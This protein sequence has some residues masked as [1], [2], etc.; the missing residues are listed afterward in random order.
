[1]SVTALVHV[2]TAGASVLALWVFVRLG[3]RRPRFAP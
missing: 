2:M 3:D 1:M